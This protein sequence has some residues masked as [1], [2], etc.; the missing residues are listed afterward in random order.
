MTRDEVLDRLRSTR[1]AFEQ[2]MAAIPAEAFVAG[3]PGGTHS[4]KEVVHHLTAYEN[5]IVERLQAAR[6][7]ETTAF[8]RDRD[9]WE[10]FNDRIWI[11]AAEAD[12][13]VVLA[14]S[15]EVF[16]EL[17]D[18]VARLADEELAGVTGITAFIDPSW[19]DGQPMWDLIG[20]DVFEHYPMHFAALESAARR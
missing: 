14:R 16:A 5:L 4:P 10:A 12:P 1:A 7:G 3:V 9:S 15:A 20:V 18:E 11:E 17:M 2:R 6:R 13:A 8:D 19:L